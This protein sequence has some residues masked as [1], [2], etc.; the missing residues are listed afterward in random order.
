M[1][2]SAPIE[3]H[4]LVASTDPIIVEIA[5]LAVEIFNNRAMG[6]PAYSL[7]LL[8]NLMDKL[9]NPELMLEMEVMLT[10]R[11]RACRGEVTFERIFV[12][13]HAETLAASARTILRAYE[14]I[15][16]GR[17][18][19]AAKKLWSN[20]LI[21]C[22]W[23]KA[24]LLD[25]AWARRKTCCPFVLG[26]L[27]ALTHQSGRAGSYC[28]NCFG[29]EI[30]TE[31]FRASSKMGMAAA[32]SPPKTPAKKLVY[33]GGFA[34]DP[35][36]LASGM[37]WTEDLAQAAW[38]ANQRYEQKGDAF[39]LSTRSNKIES[40][41]RF[42]HE[43]EVVLSFNEHRSFEVVATGESECRAFMKKREQRGSHSMPSPLL[44]QPKEA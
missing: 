39:I 7:N 20:T 1:N 33:R 25:Y 8:A 44:F 3:E 23:M 41:A 29:P 12:A 13:Q 4:K 10:F 40:L 14:V 22:D 28:I 31:M 15:D 35:S 37:S 43:N 27:V 42:E 9:P 34:S 38:F 36:E 11:E 26:F 17:G 16:T 6:M 19:K 32:S 2:I 24:E 30:T 21:T 18:P 5:E